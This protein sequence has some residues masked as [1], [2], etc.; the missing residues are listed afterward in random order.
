MR[1]FAAR[2]LP[3]VFALVLFAPAAARAH[4]S[5]DSFLALSI[6]DQVVS[7]EASVAV[8]DLE[9]ALGLDQNGDG[10]IVWSEIERQK[11]PIERLVLSHL[12]VSIPGRRCPLSATDLLVE[13]RA[14]GAYAYLK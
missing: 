10:S 8:R 6:R 1:P 4:T 14:D 9:Y 13:K 5:S 12:S 7:G 3:F 2:L 11:L